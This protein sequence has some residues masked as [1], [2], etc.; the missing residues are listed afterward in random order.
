MCE[1]KKSQMTVKFYIYVLKV[2]NKMY[3]NKFI[4]FLYF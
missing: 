2:I 4:F 1:K 3:H